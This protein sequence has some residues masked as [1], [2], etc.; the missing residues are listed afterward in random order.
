M[1]RSLTCSWEYSAMQR[2]MGKQE[3]ENLE[4]TGSLPLRVAKATQ[5]I[6]RRKSNALIIIFL[7]D[8]TQALSEMVHKKKFYIKKTQPNKNY[9]ASVCPERT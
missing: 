7:P 1:P 4:Q 2:W 3:Q 6:S 9:S 5:L 8:K